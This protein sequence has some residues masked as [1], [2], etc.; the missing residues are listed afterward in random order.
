MGGGLNARMFKI[1][2]TIFGRCSRQQAADNEVYSR[3]QGEDINYQAKVAR[4]DAAVEQHSKP[5]AERHE[6]AKAGAPKQGINS[7]EFLGDEE[8]H[9]D[10]VDAGEEDDAGGDVVGF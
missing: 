5:R 9:L 3:E 4:G 1:V 6:Q 10:P 7:H 2:G 8:G